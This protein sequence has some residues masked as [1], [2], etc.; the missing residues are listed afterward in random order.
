MAS[1]WSIDINQH[2]GQITFTP[3][4]VP[5]PRVG[6]PLGVNVG[7]NVTWYTTHIKKSR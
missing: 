2:D 1:Q 3:D 5:R 4:L 7:D 6:Q